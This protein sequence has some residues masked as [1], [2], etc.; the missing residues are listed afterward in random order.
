MRHVE[1]L[2]LRV[3]QMERTLGDFAEFVSILDEKREELLVGE[4]S[5]DA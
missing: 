4:I 3:G 2:T 1:P 5:G